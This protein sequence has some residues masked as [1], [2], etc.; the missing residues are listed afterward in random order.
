[1]ILPILGLNLAMSLCNF[2]S[3]YTLDGLGATF[4]IALDEDIAV[5][6]SLKFLS[7]CANNS[8]LALALQHH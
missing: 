8:G 1:M 7:Y 4:N 5:A 2:S 3:Q 6:K